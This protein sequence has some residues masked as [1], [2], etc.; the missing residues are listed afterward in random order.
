MPIDILAGSPTLRN[1]IEQQVPLEEIAQSWR[2]GEAEFT[3]V[4]KA[5]LL[6]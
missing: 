1:Q 4:R 2:P 6:Y 5:Y 3:E